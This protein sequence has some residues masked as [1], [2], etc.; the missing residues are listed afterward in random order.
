MTFLFAWIALILS[1]L[2]FLA[3]RAIQQNMNRL[4]IRMDLLERAKGVV[5]AETWRAKIRIPRMKP[6][7]RV[8]EA[9]NEGDALRQLIVDGVKP[10]HI[11]T[12]ERVS[13]DGPH[14]PRAA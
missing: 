1:L 14:G 8:I 7:I 2:A 9:R 11:E 4:L 10:Q 6:C 5:S 3:N 13:R 12:L